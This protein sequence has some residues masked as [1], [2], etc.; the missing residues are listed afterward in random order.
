VVQLND[1]PLFNCE[2]CEGARTDLLPTPL[3][4]F[5]TMG[6]DVF[7]GLNSLLFLARVEHFRV[8]LEVGVG[9]VLARLEHI[10]LTLV[11]LVGVA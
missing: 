8:E 2:T 9:L 1:S 7:E 4:G 3:V 10:A 5:F 11:A 6:D